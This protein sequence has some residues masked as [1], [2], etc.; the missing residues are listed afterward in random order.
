MAD[1]DE[2]SP[3][4]GVNLAALS[5]LIR[6]EAVLRAVPTVAA[7]REW[8]RLMMHNLNVPTPGYIGKY[9]GEPGLDGV[10]VRIGTRYG[11]RSALVAAE[12]AILEQTL[13]SALAALDE[14]IAIDGALTADQFKAVI[15]VCAWLH[16]EWVRIHPFANGNGRMARV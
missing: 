15:N 3:E 12:L 2:D 16:A 1:W 8:H 9:R 4:L 14:D 6:G 11:V 10:N 5:L 7:A 13:Q